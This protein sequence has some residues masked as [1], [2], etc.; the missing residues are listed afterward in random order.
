MDLVEINEAFAAQYLGC[1]KELELDRSKV[2]VNGGAIALGHPL[3]ATGTRLVLTLMHE[4]RRTKLRYGVASACIG[5]GQGIA[6]LI[7]NAAL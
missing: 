4:L 6:I 3:G 2:N 1:E 7:E 5:G